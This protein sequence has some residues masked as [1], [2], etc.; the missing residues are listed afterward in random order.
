MPLP[1]LFWHFILILD[2]PLPIHSCSS[3]SCVFLDPVHSSI[4][5][6][7]VQVLN[8]EWYPLYWHLFNPLWHVFYLNNIMSKP[9][10][11]TFS[12]LP[13]ILN[14]NCS[15][16]GSQLLYPTSDLKLVAFPHSIHWTPVLLTLH[17]LLLLLHNLLLYPDWHQTKLHTAVE[18]PNKFYIPLKNTTATDW[19]RTNAAL[20]LIRA[21]V[22]WSF[23]CRWCI[24]LTWHF[25]PIIPSWHFNYTPPHLSSTVPTPTW[26]TCPINYSTLTYR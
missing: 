7:Y 5:N 21:S 3:P 12:L 1:S 20:V 9:E 8:Y 25:L 14:S 15:H 11:Y 10:W 17:L 4:T 22:P 16:H 19:I 18:D 26:L 24:L 23:R 2:P 6:H 13:V